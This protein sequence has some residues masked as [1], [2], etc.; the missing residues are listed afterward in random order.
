MVDPPTVQVATNKRIE[1]PICGG[2]RPK[3]QV[4]G[5]PYMGLNIQAEGSY[6]THSSQSRQRDL[7]ITLQ[8][9]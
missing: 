1:S 6:E 5:I 4:D 3:V 2:E 8:V 9:S 7:T